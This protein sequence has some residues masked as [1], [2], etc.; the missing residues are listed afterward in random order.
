MKRFSV[1]SVLLFLCLG[2]FAQDANSFKTDGN[3]ALGKKDYANAYKNFLGALKLIEA[4]GQS[5]EALSHNVGYCAYKAK[6]Y[7]E[8]IPYLETS[9]FGDFKEALPHQ[10]LVVSHL[11][12]KNIEEAEKAVTN[13]LENYPGDKN[14]K[15][16]AAKIYFQL[17][18]IPYQAGN[19]IIKS[20]NENEALKTDPDAY[21]VEV[22]K[23]KLEYDKAIPLLEK[24]YSYKPKN[25]SLITKF[26]NIYT[27]L[28]DTEKLEEY[29]QA[30]DALQ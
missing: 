4:D 17:G 6:M 27:V 22:E 26:V 21:N 9:I 1:I 7:K 18:V 28:K 30:L 24:S 14:L 2:V 13:G 3:T 29:R 15:N 11:K 12:L 8:A 25:K 20:A 16:F 19:A 23:A 10:L 5:D